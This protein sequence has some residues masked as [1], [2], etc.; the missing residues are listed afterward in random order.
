MD[1]YYVSTSP[2]IIYC[3]CCSRQT[4][5]SRRLQKC[6]SPLLISCRFGAV[7]N[8]ESLTGTH[9]SARV[10]VNDAGEI[11]VLR[12][13]VQLGVAQSTMQDF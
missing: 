11:N 1:T 9:R 4:A 5:F 6:E 13:A 2:H 3:A 8:S 12:G 10:R 7:T